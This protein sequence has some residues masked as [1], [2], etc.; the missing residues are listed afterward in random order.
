MNG[1]VCSVF[2]IIDHFIK[3]FEKCNPS[4]LDKFVPMLIPET[5]VPE[6][7]GGSLSNKDS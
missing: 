5:L 6:D 3:A 7:Q 1:G 2:E 4:V